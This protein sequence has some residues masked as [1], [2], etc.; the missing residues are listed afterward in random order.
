MEVD[1]YSSIQK[2]CNNFGKEKKVIQKA[3]R[4]TMPLNACD[5]KIKEL[6]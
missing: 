4:K 1:S 5:S 6:D 3:Q 2:E